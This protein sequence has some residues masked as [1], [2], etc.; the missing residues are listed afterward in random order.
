MLFFSANDGTNGF[1]LWKSD[2]SENGTVQVKDINP[3][4]G[5]GSYPR[6]LT[7]VSGELF[8]SANDTTDGR[9]LWKSDGS[10]DGTVQVKDINPN[11]GDGS[12]PYSLTNVNGML[13]FAANDGTN[14]NELWKS[15]GS[16]DGTVPVKD[17]NPDPGDG[18]YPRYLTNVSG[19]LFFS[20]NDGTNGF[21]LWRSNGA[22]DGTLLVKDINPNPGD[23]S[24][25]SYLA[26]SNG[27]LYFSADDGTHGR[28]PWVL[29]VPAVVTVNG[30]ADFPNQPDTFLIIRD[31][32]DPTLVNIYRNGALFGTF[33]LA[34]LVQIN[35]NGRGGNDSLTVDASNGFL[36]IPQG[37]HYDG[38]GG[39]DN[40]KL[41]SAAG[42]SEVL[43]IGALPGSGKDTVTDTDEVQVVDFEN[44]EPI[45]TDNALDNFQITGIAGLASLLQAA[46]AI[47]YTQSETDA[48][49]G[50]DDT[51]GK[52]T[53]DNF[54]PIYFRN[55]TA[56]TIDAG[57]GSDEINLNNPST[58]DGLED[59]LITGGDPTASDTLIVNG[60]TVNDVIA[61]LPSGSASGDVIVTNLPNTTFDT[62]EHLIVNGQGGGDALFIVTGALE[63][64]LVL[65][66]GA[67]FDSGRVDFQ[68][69][70]AD[71]G[72][73]APSLEFL[74]L[75]NDGALVVF[76]IGEAAMDVDFVYRGTDLS[77][78]FATF[79]ED[80]FAVVALNS[81]ILVALVAVSQ[82]TLAGLDGDDTF[83]VPGMTVLESIV[84]DAGNPGASDV[85]NYSAE[86]DSETTVNFETQEITSDVAGV[87]PV[88]F[89]GVETVSIFGS[90]GSQDDF[91]V[92]D[93]GAPTDVR[94]LNLD[95]GDT[96]GNDDADTITIF[97]T[98][99][100]DTINYTP[101]SGQSAR[102]T[103]SQ[104][105]PQIN[106][107]NFNNEDGNLFVVNTGNVD[108]LNVLASAADDTIDVIQPAAD[109]TRVTVNAANVIKWV[110]VDYADLASLMVSGDLGDDT[111]VVDNSFGLVDLAGGVTYDG[112]AG[113]D[114][115]RLTGDT[116]IDAATYSVGPQPGSGRMTH[117]LG[118]QTQ[119]VFFNNLEPVTDDVMAAMLTVNGTNAS[120]AINYTQSETDAVLGV[121]D[122]WGK[123][124]VDNFE[125]I[126]FRNKTALTIDAGAGS[127]EINLNNASTPDGLEDILISGGDPTASDT[128]IVAGAGVGEDIIYRPT[129]ASDGDVTIANLPD[130]TFD[131]I[132]H[133]IVNG[134]GGGHLLQIDTSAL[135]GTLVLT[136]GAS[137]DS[138]RVDFQTT[139]PAVGFIAPSL[140]FLGLGNNGAL[141]VI[142]EAEVAMV[143][144]FVYRGTDLTDTFALFSQDEFGV[145][146]LNSQILVGLLGVSQLT[147]AGLDGDDT[148]NVPGITVLESIIID[149]GNPGASDV[150]NY[151]A[152]PDS[153]TTVD[154]ETEQITSD[155][156]GVAPVS[157]IGVETVTI[158]GS[159]NSQDD[160]IVE[161]YGAPTDVRTLN[162]D[163]QDVDNDD[164][165]TITIFTTAGPDT[166]NYTPTSGQSARFTRSQGGPQINVVFFNN[167]DGN[168]VVVNSGNVDALIVLASATNDTIDVIQPAADTTRVTVN[169]ANVIKW[170]PVDYADL[171]SLMVSGDLG[172][173]TLVVDNSGGLIELA[174][175]V[176][177]D[178]GGGVDL[179]RL[180]G[181]IEVTSSTYTVGPQPGSG[182]VIHELEN[183]GTETQKVFFDNVEPVIDIVVAFSLIVNANNA[184]NAINYVQGPN[185]GGAPVSFFES[186]LVSVDDHETMEFARKTNLVINALAGSDTI[187][188]NN[189]NTPEDLTDIEV[190]GGDPTASDTLIVGGTPFDDEITYTP[191]G[192]DRGTVTVNALPLIAF[193]TTEHLVINGQGGGDVMTIDTRAIEGTLVLTPGASFDSGRV[194]FQTNPAI[195]GFIAPS[196]EFLGIGNDGHLAVDNLAGASDVNFVYR[197]TD[198]S[199]SFSF[200]GT[201]QLNSQIPVLLQNVSQLKLAGLD[202]DD[203]FNVLALT[204]ESIVIDGGNPG[205][206]DVLNYTAVLDSETTVDF[207]TQQITSDGAGVAPV[208][209]IGVETVS[210][211]GS[212]NS[213]D[214]FIV[215]SYG[216]PT[217]VRTLNLDGQDVDNDDDD[218]ITIFTTA[219]PDTINYTPTSGQSAR[220]T[221]SQGGPQINVVFF[222][223]DDGNLVVVNSGNVDAL[224]VL[225]ST[226]NDTIDVI[227]PDADTT[228][229]TVNAANAIKWVPVDYVDLASLV[230]NGDLGDD[231]LVVDNS[232]GL[233]DL[234]GGVT[235]DG[236]AG[237]DQL[238]LTGDTE[239]DAATYSVGP[240][241]GSGRMTHVL[242][243]LTQKVFFNNLEPVT[244]DVMAAML[245]VN[246][247]NASNAID[248]TESETDAVL[249]VDPSWGKVTVDNFEPVYFQ[250][251]D[252]L[253]ILALAGSDTINLNNPTNPD[254]LLAIDVLGGNPTG[255]PSGTDTVIVNGTAAA[256]SI[257]VTYGASSDEAQ[258]TGAQQVPVNVDQAEK[259]IIDGQGG[260]DSLSIGPGEFD[261]DVMTLTP[262]PNRDSGTVLANTTTGTS[263]L[264]IEY[265]NLAG[266]PVA[267]VTPPTPQPPTANFLALG[268]ANTLVYNGTAASDTFYVDNNGT[269]T[270]FSTLS[271][272][273]VVPDVV[274]LRLNGLGG[275]DTF[276]IYAPQPYDEIL[277]DGG[278]PS[279]SDDLNLI[280][281]AGAETLAVNFFSRQVPP[282]L[283]L[284]VGIPVA[285]TVTGLGATIGITGVEGVNLD[286][287]GGADT[288]TVNGTSEDDL[289]TYT[290]TRVDATADDGIFTL[291]GFNQVFTFNQ[292]A[293]TFTIDGGAFDAADEVIVKGTSGPDFI[294]VDSPNR[295]VTVEDPGGTARK[296]VVL[297]EEIEI[298]SVQA[299][300]GNDTILV[301][302]APA[303]ATGP[304]GA[305]PGTAVPLNLLVNVDGG[306]PGASD[307][308]VIADDGE[309]LPDTDFVVINRSRTPDQGVV[310]I[311]RWDDEEDEI[312][313]LPDITYV[314]TEIVSPLLPP[315]VNP[316]QDP[317][318]MILG[319]DNYEQNEFLSTA[320]FLGSASTINATNL[321]IFPN[322]F[323]HRFV[324]ADQDWFRV[325]ARNTGTLDFQV[326]FR[327]FASAGPGSI[328]GGGN[329][330]LEAF[331][332]NGDRVDNVPPGFGTNDNDADER[333]RIPVVAGQTYYLHVFGATAQAFNGYNMTVINEAPPVPYAL[334]LYDVIVPGAVAAGMSATVFTSVSPELS[335]E[336]DAYNGKYIHFTSGNANG[337]RG[338][339]LD[340]AFAAGTATFTLAAPLAVTPQPIAAPPVVVIPAAG[341]TFEIESNDTGRSQLDNVT[342]DDTPTIF[343][344]LDD[345]IF[346]HDLPGN[347]ADDAPPDQVIPI[348]FRN[349]TEA[350]GYRIAIFDEGDVPPQSSNP[351]QDPLG[352]A[353][354]VAGQEGVY[355]FTFTTALSPGSHF[356]TARVQM[357]DPANP[358]RTG[359]GAR[360]LTLEIVVD[361]QTP[362]VFFGLPFLADDGLDAGSDT[363]VVG[364]PESFSDNITSN[365]APTFFGTA[366]ADAVIKVFVDLNDDGNL[367]PTDF[368]IGQTVATP[369]DG[370]NQFPGGRWVVTSNVDLNNPVYFP[371]DGLRTIFVTA[372]DPAGNQGPTP[373]PEVLA[374]FIDTQGPQVTELFITDFPQYDLFGLK[375]DVEF[376]GPTPLIFSLTIRLQDLPP[377]VAGFL[378]DAI[379]ERTAETPGVI[380]L[381]GDHNGI[382]EID[383]IIAT[384]IDPV[385]GMPAF[386]TI[387]LE[388]DTPLPDDRFTL[389]VNDTIT[390]P[391][392]NQLDGETD[393][394]EPTGAPFIP[395]S[396]DGQPGGDFVARFTVDSRPEI[397][398]YAAANI[399]ID[400][401]GNF[402][403]D[404]PGDDDDF[405]NRDLNFALGIVPA[406]AGVVSPMGVHDGVFAGNFPVMQGNEGPPALVADGF[407]KL[408]AY[409]FDPVAGGFRWLIDTNHDGVIDPAAGDHAT[410]QGGGFQI[411]GLPVAGDF[412]GNSANGDEIGLFDGTRWHFDTN[413]NYVIDAG[414]LVS[415]TSL[416]G[417]PIVGDFNG[418]GTLDLATWRDDRFYFNF[419]T[420][421]PSWTGAVNAT[422]AWGL[423][424]V[425]ELP[426]AADMDQ[427]GITD[428]GLFLPARSG[429]LPISSGN[430]QF[431]ISNDFDEEFRG[432]NQVTALNHP[433]SPA[434]LGNDLFAQFGDAFA[435]PI[436]GNFDPPTGTPQ[437]PAPT[438][439]GPVLGSRTMGPQ[440]I[441]G[442]QWYA[443]QSLR[444]GTVSVDASSAGSVSVNLYSE[445]FLQM[446]SAAPLA[447]G[448]AMAS[449]EVTAG[450]TYLVRL[451]SPGATATLHISN[452]VADADRFDTSRDGRVTARDAL[453][454]VNELLSIPRQ[455][456][457]MVM[458]NAK[459]YLDTTLDGM[460]T[461]RDV[462]QLIN[463]LLSQPAASPRAAA[464]VS[465]DLPDAPSAPGG[466]EPAGSDAARAAV[467]TGLA[468]SGFGSAAP[469]ARAP[470]IEPKAADAVY[471]QLAADLMLAEPGDSLSADALWTD[472]S[473]DD[474]LAETEDIDLLI[475]SQWAQ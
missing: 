49:L 9:E 471:T 3:N 441:S 342:R 159:D 447:A 354:A 133:L 111:L 52:V 314:G 289:F 408:A 388:F 237:A 74:G 180:I 266:D 46:N 69:N 122:T 363:G 61:Y 18:S 138:G 127:D 405:T 123:V 440:T 464:A 168:L 374:I 368:L 112:G 114:Q 132:E 400:A 271:Y 175:G 352:F 387:T 384:N 322:G 193:N 225:A 348:P 53:V 2:G 140:E 206:S 214:D 355:L 211:F 35:V 148:F 24:D 129:G 397:G 396:G 143:V 256:D 253:R 73:I 101:T 424:G 410:I 55:K 220:F 56:L 102:F 190:D 67:S 40:L 5:D 13:F 417:T 345:G 100:P 169:A 458:G 391:A 204:V 413:H 84:I 77:D 456:T 287:E 259:L 428:I 448:P 209:F 420:A 235:Y 184:D 88:S 351:P 215:E 268:P 163:G 404:F 435:L 469:A 161:S 120:N 115:L 37:I 270:L 319:P 93:Y 349:Q 377:R 277:V 421:G 191:D 176:T 222:N 423:P 87:A 152:E 248:Y 295:T 147:L 260:G 426:L 11:T 250:N 145:V 269:V 121:D 12:Y 146:S 312:L 460:I 210:I 263:L 446:T 164:D 245:T 79:V 34:S 155:L 167:D 280:G 189:P 226:T 317:N 110:P 137:F 361:V 445:D 16:Q 182:H 39:F 315:P 465:A 62:I 157:F 130:T 29:G 173:D 31:A 124:T 375:P 96:E 231:T 303:T 32:D 300:G 364:L 356:I 334:E 188:L 117:V 309:N 252:L 91:V 318:L 439:I 379:V 65:T 301:T 466:S 14:G 170:V 160:F 139:P 327:E 291:A 286:G 255:P 328:P 232:G 453:L 21:E 392:G 113:A 325:V 22:E 233:V 82:L 27:T 436:V 297:G 70:L 153:E 285:I 416:R 296:P 373:N 68:T 376:Q 151:S 310:R 219:G 442:Q 425:S 57:A 288:L 203:V 383:R 8:F 475:D 66:P 366:E 244:D 38:G 72:F 275:D 76:N 407:D 257:E 134:Q 228:R 329:L 432:G 457:P 338:L 109:T 418:D 194:D 178:G 51:W 467:A 307:A 316:A 371:K 6:Y 80:E 438:A 470:A 59:I 258:V 97:T 386:A 401:N 462:H 43:A 1:E 218:T 332:V 468:M 362:P 365:T 360:S 337:L 350:A 261:L 411:N 197:G 473:P 461:L 246:G 344:R 304:G 150:L 212:D 278:A 128:L 455:A 54:E 335:T 23:G 339:I 187:H 179:V 272:L 223:N 370:S 402:F 44:I 293:G 443:F 385:A 171:A 17:I 463:Y 450:N 308:L 71:D 26:N 434:P 472:L 94:T 281:T 243:D 431:L 409:G 415:P 98:D 331:D 254:G 177:F 119:K 406:L 276:N 205:A 299:L 19:T 357:I 389:T 106:V 58:P 25:P 419:G 162:L 64:T 227:Q 234:A 427:D 183:E 347:P 398:T 358:T 451:N 267:P 320:A 89:I 330:S 30:D 394:V 15:D 346:L 116:E 429:T 107:A 50:V 144:D 195:D 343:L 60:T 201:V 166:I 118:D 239:I 323:E 7:N 99:G 422:I 141:A 42:S 202:G 412:D 192:A 154:F 459:L 199:D 104:G 430:W 306:S 279:A 274:D 241:P 336:N 382:I 454:L 85:L 200:E 186:G 78:T 390:D 341:S 265:L 247:T 359:F 305:P 333:I 378:Y 105:G 174:G 156:A 284:V 236:G 273:S 81:Q 47:N 403:A 369:I 414:D 207:Q 242:V 198:L 393:A 75:G 380:L 372:E 251:K 282:S 294:D 230:V 125:P 10:E 86:A 196:L 20:A 142:N 33:L 158:F 399:F 131:T 240:Q 103:R 353:S 165:D 340:Y 292:I 135:G 367:D 452:R 474:L 326:Y 381:V 217:D 149:G 213:Q 185:S 208:S 63:G 449:G 302:P 95:T 262:G 136:P 224:I 172:D 321:A 4:P 283:P 126:Y 41:V 229:V 238:R 221:R 83:E 264:A 45:T 324:P 28:E 298:V 290:P 90:D 36:T 249:M 311:Y 181:D 216:A 92:T 433:F 48:V 108:A 444:S 437:L 395:P 313:T